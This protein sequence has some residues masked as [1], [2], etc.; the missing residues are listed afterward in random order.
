MSGPH[1]YN[2]KLYFT[3]IK[4]RPRNVPPP[5]WFLLLETDTTQW[6]RGG[7]MVV[8]MVV[9]VVMVVVWAYARNGGS[10]YSNQSINSVITIIIII[11]IIAIK[12]VLENKNTLGISLLQVITKMYSDDRTNCPG[13]YILYLYLYH[14]KI[15]STRIFKKL[16]KNLWFGDVLPETPHFFFFFFFFFYTL[17]LG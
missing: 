12:T 1:N 17:G 6:L 5:P 15:K 9:E 8:A 4:T 13:F 2:Y 10:S 11:V 3:K 7:L 14:L 16:I